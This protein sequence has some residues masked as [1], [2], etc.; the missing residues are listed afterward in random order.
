[1]IPSDI[2]IVF[3]S[4]APLRAFFRL[5]HQKSRAL[6]ED[7]AG[8]IARKRLAGP[9]RIAL[10]RLG[11]GSGSIEH[12]DQR[13]GKGSLGSADDSDIEIAICD[14]A[15]RLADGDAR[16]CTSTRMG[17]YGAE[18][19]VPYGDLRRATV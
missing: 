5:K 3:R 14:R 4:T 1:A 16:G 19:L 12:A 8:T 17:H 13:R 2:T 18:D 7:Q 10:V 15:H 11:Q 6:S 9:C